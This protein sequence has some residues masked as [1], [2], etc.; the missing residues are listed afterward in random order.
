M[1]HLDLFSGIGGFALAARW[2]GWETVGFCEIDSYCQKV[3][4]KHWPDVPI[5][6]DI[7]EYD[8]QECDIITGGFPCQPYSHAGKQRGTDDDRHLWPE[9]RRIVSRRRP[10]WYVGENVTGIIGME[11]DQVLFDL[12]DLGYSVDVFVLPACSV[13]AIHR[14]DRVFIVAHANSEGLQRIEDA[15]LPGKGWKGWP[16]HITGLLESERRL[17][18]PTGKC[19]GVHD[20]VS[21]RMD[22]LKGLGNAIVPQ[23]AEVIFRAINEVECE[24]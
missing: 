10:R 7:K 23:V 5:H 19:G 17:A 24:R 4:R 18:V 1:R 12:E 16:Q 9:N 11:L 20:G 21:N 2:V 14:R 6:G 22:R 8:G 3:L 13:N 15:G